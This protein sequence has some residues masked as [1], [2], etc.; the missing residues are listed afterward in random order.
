MFSPSGIRNVSGRVADTPRGY[1]V[2]DDYAADGTGAAF[3]REVL[4]PEVHD[5]GV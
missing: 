5:G 3:A 1:A 2:D 4:S